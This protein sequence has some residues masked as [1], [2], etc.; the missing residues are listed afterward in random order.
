MYRYNFTV[1]YVSSGSIIVFQ[2]ECKKRCTIVRA[3]ISNSHLGSWGP[4]GVLNLGD[5]ILFKGKCRN[6]AS[7]QVSPDTMYEVIYSERATCHQ[8]FLCFPQVWFELKL[9]LWRLGLASHY[10]A[11]PTAQT[12]RSLMYCAVLYSR[13]VMPS[14]FTT[15]RPSVKLLRM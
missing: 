11:P 12:L 1:I 9:L 14:F 5:K 15:M 4:S 3:A 8:G 10:F 2:R 6:L 7:Y 13:M